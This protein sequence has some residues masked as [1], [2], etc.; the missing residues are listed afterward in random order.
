MRLDPRR[1]P[2][3]TAKV[4]RKHGGW[5][6]V[7]KDFDARDKVALHV[8]ATLSKP[9]TPSHDDVVNLDSIITAGVM[10][11]VPF[12]SLPGEGARASYIVPLP[13]QLA[14]VSD[15]GNPLWAATEMRPVGLVQKGV[16][17]I[18]KRH[19][20][21]RLNLHMGGAVVTTAGPLKDVR[22]PQYV[23]LAEKVE[24]WCIGAPDAIQAAL[25]HITHIGKKPSIGRGHVLSWHVEPAD[26][27]LAWIMD[28]RACP[29][30][31]VGDCGP[32][33]KQHTA[34]SPPYWDR[35]KH[36]LCRVAS[37]TA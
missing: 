24:G 28:R 15:D 5:S 22:V 13:L 36:G 8:Q 32:E 30:K 33:R 2:H 20:R 27:D 6:A 4:M 11:I 3:V 10:S 23:M 18:H 34:W 16:E 31:S 14:W 35:T 37:W 19:P 17:Y 25:S 12:G 9:Y 21:D 26:V 1:F 29:I 7:Q